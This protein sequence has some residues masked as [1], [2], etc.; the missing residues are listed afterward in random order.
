V[1]W[2]SCSATA[3]E[4]NWRG[5]KGSEG[6]AKET[7]QLCWVGIKLKTH[8]LLRFEASSR[9]ELSAR[10]GMPMQANGSRCEQQHRV[11]GEDRGQPLQPS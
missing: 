3:E 8:R 4:E 5:R 10:R 9:Q 2:G 1:L 7:D 11:R 6:A